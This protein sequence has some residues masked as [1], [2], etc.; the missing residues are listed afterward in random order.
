[1]G[2]TQTKL[3][4]KVMKED[5]DEVEQRSLRFPAE[6][7]TQNEY[8][9]LPLHLACYTGR[10]P[11]GTIAALAREYPQ[12]VGTRN[13]R[14]LTALDAARINYKADNPHRHQVLMILGVSVLTESTSLQLDN[15]VFTSASP[16]QCYHNEL[17]VICMERPVDTIL[18]P[19]GHACICKECVVTV[20]ASGVCPMGRCR[21]DAIR[22]YS[23]VA[24]EEVFK[25]MQEEVPEIAQRA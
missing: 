13:S 7:R 2:L 17:C 3:H 12:S 15:N 19:C 21:I 16:A 9:D 23:E 4:F 1:M 6:V 20:L 24:Q 18:I 5:W 8:G 25:F 14:G 22:K 11:A 10:A